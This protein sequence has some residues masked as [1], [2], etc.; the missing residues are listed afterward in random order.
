MRYFALILAFFSSS[1]FAANYQFSLDPSSYGYSS[2][3][4]AA[5]AKY[6]AQLTEPYTGHYVVDA[7][8]GEVYYCYATPPGGSTDVVGVVSRYGDSCPSGGTYYPATGEC[9]QP[10]SVCAE[11]Q[12]QGANKRFSIAGT[13]GPGTYATLVN[14]NG[15][16]M[17][18]PFQTA[19]MAGCQMSTVDQKCTGKTT[20]AFKCVGTA[21]YTGQPCTTSGTSSS[22]EPDTVATSTA[23]PQPVTLKTDK[24]CTYVVSGSTS[25]CQ[26]I[27]GED[28]EG[29]QC[30]FVNGVRK[31]YTKTPYKYENKIDTTSVKTTSGA[32]TITTKTD[33]L[34]RTVCDGVNNC[35]TTTT[36]TVTTTT[37][38]TT[39]GAL[40][41]SSSTCD[42]PDCANSGNPD[43]NGDGFGDST[44]DGTC[45][46]DECGEGEGGAE[47]SHGDIEFGELEDM[48]TFAE[49]LESFNDQL[50]SAPIVQALDNLSLSSGG[51]TCAAGTAQTFFGSINFNSFC[52][53]APQVLDPLR[54][55]FLA[56]WAW[57]AIRLFFTA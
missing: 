42:G 18:V 34:T 54:Y 55:L 36:T 19:C 10:P 17:F 7:G 26:S 20:G 50:M 5:C 8:G 31:C 29:Q 47:F 35:K 11:R 53:L 45:Q 27:K 12:Q 51:G 6:G 37:T 14:F 33:K 22:P 49:S 25:T 24:P 40:L 13:A 56:I 52:D 30:G 48:P 43:A 9:T 44:T 28:I 46:G 2:T 32:N 39:G 4:G 15:K 38:K 21:Y 1:S 3:A 16:P 57:A 23:E 41:D